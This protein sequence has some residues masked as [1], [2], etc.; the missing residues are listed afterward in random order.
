MASIRVAEVRDAA[1]IAPRQSRIVEL[2]FFRG[3]SFEEIASLLQASGR[4]VK[5]DR[6][7]ARN[8]LFKEVSR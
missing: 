5:R 3:L 7:M 1:A 6:A 8:W 2:H 4:T